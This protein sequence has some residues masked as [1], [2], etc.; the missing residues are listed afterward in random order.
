MKTNHA[1]K[2]EKKEN[3]LCLLAETLGNIWSL[4]LNNL[5]T[6]AKDKKLLFWVDNYYGNYVFIRKRG[7]IRINTDNF[8][9]L[10]FCCHLK[11]KGLLLINLSKC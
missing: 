2:K 8:L 3:K 5:S 10:F 7:H 9:S 4:I 6:R 11:S 1:K